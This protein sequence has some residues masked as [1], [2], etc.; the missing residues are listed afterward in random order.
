MPAHL[1]GSGVPI[2]SKQ[3]DGGG[4][5]FSRR[6]KERYNWGS[7]AEVRFAGACTALIASCVRLATRSKGGW[8][9]FQISLGCVE[10]VWEKGGRCRC[11]AFVGLGDGTRNV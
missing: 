4:E 5:G 8:G 1:L 3:D 10:P 11:Q 6:R 2:E 7:S 9:R